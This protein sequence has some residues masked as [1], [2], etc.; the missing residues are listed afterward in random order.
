MDMIDDKK[1]DE[2]DKIGERK[3]EDLKLEESETDERD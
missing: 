1:S 2:K 3:E